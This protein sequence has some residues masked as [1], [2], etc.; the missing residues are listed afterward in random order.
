MELSPTQWG[1]KVDYDEW[2]DRY[3]PD[4]KII[5]HYGGGSAY[6]T[7]D[8]ASE[9]RVLRS[10]E[11]T[12]LNKGWRGLAYGWAIGN[13]GTIYRGRGF[14]SYGAHQGDLDEDGIFENSEGIPVVFILG[15]DE[16]PSVAALAS[17]ANLRTVT[18][19]PRAGRKLPVYGHK[20]IAE[21]GSGTITTCPGPPL[22]AH[23]KIERITGTRIGQQLSPGDT[24]ATYADIINRDTVPLP[25]WSVASSE[26][27][28]TAGGTTLKLETLGRPAFRFDIAWFWD[29]F[30]RPLV[31]TVSALIVRVRNLE[32][33][34]KA[35]V[36]TN[37]ELANRV[38][39]LEARPVASGTLAGS[40]EATITIK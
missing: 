1:A 29:N 24:M 28:R 38:A 8:L 13:S 3:T 20:E 33:N 37:R 40:Y 17:F 34:D 23:I 14:N 18:L 2:T 27:Y 15:V 21:L 5:I 32:S 30:F 19:E 10:F 11:Q 25:D 6:K 31:E 36:V 12:H 22:M 7:N 35:Q 9:A 16:T 39:A 4:D 26:A